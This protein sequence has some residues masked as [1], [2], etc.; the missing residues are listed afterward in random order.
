[1]NCPYYGNRMCIGRLSST[2]GGIYFIPQNS[3]MKFFVLS[4]RIKIQVTFDSN[5][6]VKYYEEC[7]KIII[8][9]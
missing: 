8:N 3:R 9:I 5:V 1:M 7:K 2:R 6:V 4:E